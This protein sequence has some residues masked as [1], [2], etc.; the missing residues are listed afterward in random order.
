MVAL[1]VHF[2]DPVMQD[3]INTSIAHGQASFEINL[4]VSAL[5]TS[6][7][8]LQSMGLKTIDFESG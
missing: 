4:L 1:L 3:Q 6:G 2:A 5:F 8:F 7:N